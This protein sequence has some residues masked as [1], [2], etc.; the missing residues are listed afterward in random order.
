MEKKQFSP[1]LDVVFHM[2]FGEPKNENITKRLIED[3]IGE[4]VENIDLNINPYLWGE[5]PN[6]KLGI[7][8]IRAKINNENPVDIEMQMAESENL[9]K[10]ILFYWS[11]MYIKQIEKGVDYEKLNKCISIVFTDFKIEK[12]GGLPQHTK[13]QIR[14]SKYGKEV[15]TEE[16]EINIIELGKA[17]E[18]KENNELTK[19]LM[20]LNDPYGEEAKKV[21]EKEKVVF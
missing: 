4:K 12:L 8:D 5:Q 21:A 11:R 14:E 7:V 17:K 13:W 18:I 2:L 16:L 20:F 6:D 10:R 15:L 1:K 19:W 3:V 9:L